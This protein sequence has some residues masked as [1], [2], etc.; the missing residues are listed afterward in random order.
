MCAYAVIEPAAE[1]EEAMIG[2]GLLP[3]KSNREWWDIYENFKQDYQKRK[4]EAAQKQV[5][6]SRSP[7]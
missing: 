6:S 2:W 3:R 4:E 7:V 5:T 1:E